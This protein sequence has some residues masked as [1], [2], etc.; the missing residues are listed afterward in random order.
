MDQFTVDPNQLDSR[1][2][3]KSDK[4][5]SNFNDPYCFK[6]YKNYS[7]ISKRKIYWFVCEKSKGNFMIITRINS[8]FSIPL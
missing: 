2:E 6:I 8:V 5:F 4:S 1:S 7:N 3:N